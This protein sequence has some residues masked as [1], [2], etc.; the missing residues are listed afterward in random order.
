MCKKHQNKFK[1]SYHESDHCTNLLAP[2]ACPQPGTAAGASPLLF[3]EGRLPVGS[4][5]L[6]LLRRGGD[7]QHCPLPAQ[8]REEVP[9]Q[10][11]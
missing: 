5:R 10:L 11:P 2:A 7:Q 9:W 3:P 4:V 6:L 1:D 8:G